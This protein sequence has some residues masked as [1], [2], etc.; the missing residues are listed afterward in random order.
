MFEAEGFEGRVSIH[1]LLRLLRLTLKICLSCL[2]FRLSLFLAEIFQCPIDSFFETGAAMSRHFSDGIG[3]FGALLFLLLKELA[4]FLDLDAV[5]LHIDDSVLVLHVLA[6][7][8]VL[9]K[10]V[11]EDII[12]TE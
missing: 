8:A 9:L 2:L 5:L 1:D 11:T 12:D 6:V 10:D 4:E 3:N 7:F